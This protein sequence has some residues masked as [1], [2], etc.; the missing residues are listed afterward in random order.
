MD[1]LN[2]SSTSRSSSNLSKLDLSTICD[3]Y[4]DEMDNEARF[5]FDSIYENCE[6]CDICGED[7]SAFNK[8]LGDLIEDGFNKGSLDDFLI[9][10]GQ[11]KE[12]ED[13]NIQFIC[14]DDKEPIDDHVMD[15]A[16]CIEQ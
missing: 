11:A 1:G 3:N 13:T 5:E 14:V 4:N 2:I 15:E 12:V 7:E 16:D 10:L 6:V 9:V 8:H